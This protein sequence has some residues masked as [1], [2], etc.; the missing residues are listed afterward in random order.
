MNALER[1]GIAQSIRGKTPLTI[2]RAAELKTE[3][4]RLKGEQDCLLGLEPQ[5]T[6]ETYQRSYARTYERLE[7]MAHLARM[8]S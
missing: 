1:M 3:T 7:K 8:V 5:E 4:S 2:Q 6:N